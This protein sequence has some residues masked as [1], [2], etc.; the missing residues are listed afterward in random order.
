MK[1]N[2]KIIYKISTKYLSTGDELNDFLEKNQEKMDE[3][4]KNDYVVFGHEIIKNK[5]YHL[6]LFYIPY[7]SHLTYMGG[8][9]SFQE[10]N[11]EEVICGLIE[12]NK[13]ST[14]D[15]THTHPVKIIQPLNDTLAVQYHETS[16]TKEQINAVDEKYQIQ[17]TVTQLSRG[18]VKKL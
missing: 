13:V 3:H 18:K 5:P 11:T 16:F 6:Y 15:L 1:L 14:F 9:A 12:L 4:Y 10:I 8:I 7:E 2:N 17:K